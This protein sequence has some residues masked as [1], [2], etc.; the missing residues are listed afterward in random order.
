MEWHLIPKEV[1]LEIQPEMEGIHQEKM[2]WS[3]KQR[4]L[5]R[6][7]RM[8]KWNNT[9]ADKNSKSV[10]LYGGKVPDNLWEEKKISANI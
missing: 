5:L 1:W 9:K 2:W 6:P 10:Q 8:P 3:A 7:K 4:K